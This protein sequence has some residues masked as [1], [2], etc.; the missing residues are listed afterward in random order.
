MGRFLFCTANFSV[1]PPCTFEGH[2]HPSRQI[3]ECFKKEL[4]E[5]HETIPN[6]HKTI[7][8]SFVHNYVSIYHIW[9]AFTPLERKLKGA[10]NELFSALAQHMLRH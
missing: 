9:M 1:R 6:L 4:V 2:R 7:F 3:S 10:L 5:K 8:H